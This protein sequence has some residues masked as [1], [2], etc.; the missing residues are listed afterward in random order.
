MHTH[1]HPIN[2]AVRSHSLTTGAL[3]HNTSLTPP[4][5]NTTPTPAKSS[6]QQPKMTTQHIVYKKV[7]HLEDLVCCFVWFSAARL[8]Y[9]YDGPDPSS[10]RRAQDVVSVL[11]S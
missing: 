6:Q 4:H 10:S 1:T 8:S 3:L 7:G 11:S 2:D 9:S 5:H